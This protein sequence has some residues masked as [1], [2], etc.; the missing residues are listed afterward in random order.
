[1]P[2][3][4][5]TY[6][7]PRR[8]HFYTPAE[9]LTFVV[10]APDDYPLHVVKQTLIHQR[11]EKVV[12]VD[13]W[14]QKQRYRAVILT[15]TSDWYRFSLHLY[16][17]EE[18]AVNLLIVGTHDSCVPLP[19]LSFDA[20]RVEETREGVAIKQTMP[21]GKE[22]YA[23]SAEPKRYEPKQLRWSLLSMSETFRKTSYGHAML[24]GGL[25]CRLPEAS[26]RLAAIPSRY[27]RLRL[28]HEVKQLHHRRLGHPFK[29][30]EMD[31]EGKKDE[32]RK[33]A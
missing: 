33:L 2:E 9:L 5:R 21:D 19:I 29:L 12:R 18:A 8:F 15:R 25:M 32:E 13:V 17:Q 11:A 3:Q 24:I 4:R 23:I 6:R 27:G 31:A 10:E 1:M 16:A 22:Q 7:S 28:M 30:I 26:Q 20:L 14:W